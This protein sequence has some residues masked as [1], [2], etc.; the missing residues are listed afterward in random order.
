MS[1]LGCWASNP[2]ENPV[3]QP[4]RSLRLLLAPLLLAAAGT[5]L[6]ATSSAAPR[7]DPRSQEPRGEPDEDTKLGGI[8]Q[9]IRGGMRQLRGEV[10]SKD[11]A[12]AWKTVCAIQRSI[13]DAKQET[14]DAAKAKSDAER[15]AFV[16][17]FRTK[18]V[19]LLKASGDLETAIL[20]NKFDEADKVMR[21]ML[22]PIQKAGHKQFRN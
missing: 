6:F 7:Q 4:T 1:A 11:Q 16:N 15:P 9:K 13:L 8:M 18:L 12:A 5:T 2:P 14:P 17:A 10:E 19:E 3:N 21:E 20:A 22:G